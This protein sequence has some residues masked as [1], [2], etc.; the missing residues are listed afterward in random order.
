[1]TYRYWL[2]V[3]LTCLLT[4]VIGYA[5][6]STARLLQVWQPDRNLLLLPGEAF[7]RLLL[8]GACVG[9]GL[10]SGLPAETLGWTMDE[11]GRQI[12][13]GVG[14]GILMA[15]FFTVA[16]RLVTESTGKR[17]YSNL[18]IDQILPQNSREV[19]LVTL[20]MALVVLVEELLFR[21]LLLGGLTPLLPA[22]LLVGL[23]GLLFGLMH[24]PQGIWGMA[25]AMMAGI[26]L[27]ALF[28]Q[29][30]SILLPLVAHYVA[31]MAQIGWAVVVS[32]KA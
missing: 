4:G 10:L 29:A 12:A 15:L 5:T 17:F 32:E 20:S 18:I 25:G 16:T 6:Y 24:S 1:M 21:S 23:A 9:L 3:V 28:F 8:I 30:G 31:N 11:A 13:W 7:V 27:G 14:W 2:F 19:V 22:A 26:M